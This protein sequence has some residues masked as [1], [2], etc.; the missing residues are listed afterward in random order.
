MNVKEDSHDTAIVVE[1]GALI[2]FLEDS[3]LGKAFSANILENS[4]F[5]RFYVSPLTDTELKYVF[6]RRNGYQEAQ[7]IVSDILKNFIICSESN[8]RHEAIRLKCNFPISIADCYSLAVGIVLEIPVC[9]K[10]EEEI[11]RILSELLSMVQ[12]IFIDDYV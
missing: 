8:L 12:I 3:E 11:D 7:R 2:E 5:Q 10:K 6:C 9:M 1:T 4:R